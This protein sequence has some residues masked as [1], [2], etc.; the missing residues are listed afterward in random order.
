MLRLPYAV[1]KKYSW[2]GRHDYDDLISCGFWAL[3]RAARCF[4]PTAVCRNGKPPTFSSYAMLCVKTNMTRYR[5][6]MWK[7]ADRLAV[8]VSLDAQDGD[9]TSQYDFHKD[10]G[11]YDSLG[12]ED[13][14]ERH[15]DDREE[16]EKVMSVLNRADRRL[17]RLR[18]MEGHTLA[19][20][21]RKT[22]GGRETPLT[23]E[24]I[25]QKLAKAKG[26]VLARLGVEEGSGN[27]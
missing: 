12:K 7:L 19:E 26:R 22:K 11:L 23:R 4:D 9:S 5:H 13:P 16:V 20:V 17:M 8:N 27:E 24:R 15:F 14:F 6:R 1:A 21:A 2:E 18:H 25:R 3:F 10:Y